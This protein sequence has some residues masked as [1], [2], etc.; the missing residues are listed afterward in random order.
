MKNTEINSEVWQY[1]A[2][3]PDEFARAIESSSSPKEKEFFQKLL[4]KVLNETAASNDVLMNDKDNEDGLYILR[5]GTDDFQVGRVGDPKSPSYPHE[6][7]GLFYFLTA[8]LEPYLHRHIT[9][10]EWLKTRDFAGIR[11]DANNDYN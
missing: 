5:V 1:I 3:T 8:D 11:Y 4:H 7:A 9:V 2:D 6:Y 10:G